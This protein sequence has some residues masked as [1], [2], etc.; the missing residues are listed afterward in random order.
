MDG[1]DVTNENEPEIVTVASNMAQ[2][3][4]DQMEAKAIISEWTKHEKELR[5]RLLLAAGHDPDDKAPPS[6]RAV[7][8]DGRA[9][10]DI[11]VTYKIGLDTKRLK[12]HHPA[13]YADC[14]RKIMARELK[15]PVIKAPRPE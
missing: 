1:G 12:T 15:L 6:V 11:E 2:L 14:E 7:D 13:A 10:F 5:K 4:A 8:G 3:Y 9:V